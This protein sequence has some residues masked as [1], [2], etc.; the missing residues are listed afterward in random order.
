MDDQLFD[1]ATILFWW[2]VLC[3]LEPCLLGRGIMLFFEKFTFDIY[4]HVEVSQAREDT[5]SFNERVEGC[6]IHSFTN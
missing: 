4:P 6:S 1:E 3:T 2:T 5:H